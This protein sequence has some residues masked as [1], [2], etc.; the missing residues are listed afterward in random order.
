MGLHVLA[1]DEG[2]AGA[3][4]MLAAGAQTGGCYV[5][6]E[7]ETPPEDGPG[8]PH[9]H[10]S[11][12]EA[13]FVLTGQREI[14]VDGKRW[15]GGPGLFVMSP[16]RTRH[17]MRT[18]GTAPSRWLHFFSP[19]GIEDFFANRRRLQS[20]GGS[21]E[22]LIALAASYGTR[23]RPSRPPTEH[24]HGRATDMAGDLVFGG[25]HYSLAVRTSLPAEVHEHDQDEAFYVFEGMLSVNDVGLEPRSFVLVPRG[26]AHRHELNG[27]VLAVYSPGPAVPH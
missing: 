6:L 20:E 21:P 3:M 17:L 15:A 18:A 5:A 7:A 4:R 14:V 22:D 19:A 1:P 23:D 8:A 13:E 26:V 16:P 2:Y 24:A 27:A 10:E 25:D 9:S 12:A 11:W